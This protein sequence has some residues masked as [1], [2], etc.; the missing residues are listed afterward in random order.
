MKKLSLAY[1]V[2]CGL[3]LRLRCEN[4]LGAR[5]KRRAVFFMLQSGRDFGQTLPD[6]S[7]LYRPIF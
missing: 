7:C 4:C 1:A 3:V 2:F 5:K 6:P